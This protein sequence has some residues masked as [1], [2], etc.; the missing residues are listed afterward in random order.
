MFDTETTGLSSL[1]S[2]VE[3]GAVKM[4]GFKVVD[5]FHTLIRPWDPIPEEA[6]RVHGISQE[7]VRK[8]PEAKDVLLDFK[9][10]CDGSVLVAHNAP[11]DL[12]IISVHLQRLEELLW[13]NHIFDTREISKRHFPEVESHSLENLCKVWRS[14]FKGQHRALDDAR[15]T[16]FVM[17]RMAGKMGIDSSVTLSELMELWGPTLHMKRFSLEHALL[18]A[19]SAVR[20]KVERLRA[21]LRDGTPVSYTYL[22]GGEQRCSMDEVLPKAIFSPGDR[23]YVEVLSPNRRNRSW[24]CRVDWIMNLRK[25]S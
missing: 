7:M 8:A 2:L 18:N 11:F 4:R 21:A 5:T 14:P 23:I 22:K 3:L 17:S 16:A 15:H 12:K 9:E 25:G 1:S 19:P 13:E 10:F 24:V 20:E 6:L